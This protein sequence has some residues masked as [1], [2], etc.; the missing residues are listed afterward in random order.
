MSVLIGVAPPSTGVGK[1]ERTL[2]DSGDVQ[3]AVVSRHAAWG[4]GVFAMAEEVLPDLAVA[5]RFHI[6][7][8]SVDAAAGLVEADYVDGFFGGPVREFAAEV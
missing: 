2:D 6:V 1:G 4:E 7:F 5:Q 8:G 3:I